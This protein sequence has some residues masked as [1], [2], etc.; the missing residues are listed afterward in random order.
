MSID[1]SISLQDAGAHPDRGH[2]RTFTS[3]ASSRA[4]P[5][6]IDELG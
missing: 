4:D 3:S 5:L 2:T 6:A 1:T